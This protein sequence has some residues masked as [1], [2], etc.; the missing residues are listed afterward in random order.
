MIDITGYVA[1]F[2][3]D[4]FNIALS[5]LVLI[6]C[7]IVLLFLFVLEAEF[8]Q[9]RKLAKKMDD[10]EL[11]LSRDLRELRD[12]VKELGSFMSENYGIEKPLGNSSEKTKSEEEQKPHE[13]AH[14]E[15]S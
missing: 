15:G 4:L 13:D 11:I 14:K 8:R 10:E 1:L 12:S 7:V 5:K 2:G 6:M 3:I 9:I